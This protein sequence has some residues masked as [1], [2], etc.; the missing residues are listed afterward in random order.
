MWRCCLPGCKGEVIERVNYHAV[1][2]F[3]R[4]QADVKQCTPESL[5]SYWAWVRH[6]LIWA[7]DTPFSQAPSIRPVFPQYLLSVVHHQSQK[8]LTKTGVKR[9]CRV[10]RM[11]FKWLVEHK[12]RDYR[13]IDSN[14]IDT[15][16]PP[17]MDGGPP[18]KRQAVTLEMVRQLVSIESDPSDIVMTRNIA[19]AAFLFLSG[20]RATAFCTVPLS[21]VDIESRTVLQYPSLGVRTKNSKGAE[22]R[23]LEI[24]DLLAVVADW[25]SRI[26]ALIPESAL[27]FSFLRSNLGEAE[28]VDRPPGRYRRITLADNLKKLFEAAGLDYMSPHK[29]R[30]GHAIYGLSQ[31]SELADFKAVSMNLMHSSLGIT[32]S[33]YAMLTADDMKER[34]ANLGNGNGNKSVNGDHIAEVVR[35]VMAEMGGHEAPIAQL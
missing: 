22:T 29:F 9:L 23:L 35:R 14:W 7:D 27:W 28:L 1:K 17:K 16:Q 31:S 2:A 11:F 32:D 26:R 19:A 5:V 30:H 12:S 4:Y 21:C 10:A 15:L 33:I 13:R 34:I 8:P 6:L 25:D 3:L 18:V 20:M 24:P